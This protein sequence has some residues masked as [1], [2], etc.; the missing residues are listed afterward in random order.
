MAST[1]S[2]LRPMCT[3]LTFH[4]TNPATIAS[5]DGPSKIP[6]PWRHAYSVPGKFTP[7]S[8]MVRLPSISLLP[9][10]CRPL[11]GVAVGVGVGIGVALGVAVGVA[12]GEAVGVGVGLDVGVG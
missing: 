1:Q 9:E 3:T 7:C 5:S 8:W 12:V 6:Q 10:T 4:D 11:A 2:S